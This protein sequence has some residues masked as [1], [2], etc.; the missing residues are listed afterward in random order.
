VT[1]GLTAAS[2]GL[3]L[4]AAFP[5]LDWSIC[6]WFGL[7]PL[8]RAIE[9]ESVGRALRLG[10]IAGVAF[11]LVALDWIPATIVRAG[12]L[13][14]FVAV[15]PLVALAGALAVYF[16]LFA[17]GL[18]YWQIHTGRD[19]FAF[20]VVL[21][22]AL[23]WCRATTLVAC[24]WE[25]IGYSQIMN[26]R[27][28]QIADVTGVYGVSA[29]VVAMNHALHATSARR[30]VAARFALVVAFFGAA[31]LYGGHRAKEFSSK[32]G[33]KALR[34]ALVQPAID[35][36]EK[37][38]PA[39]REAALAVQEELSRAAVAGGAELVVWPEASAPYLFAADDFYARD[40]DAFARDR[41]LRD[42]T[43]AFAR[44]LATPLLIGSPAPIVHRV[45]R[46]EVWNSLNRSLL[47][48]VDGTVVAHYDKTIL[49]PFGEYVPFA[50]LLF[51]VRRLVPG[52]G[53]FVAGTEPTAFHAG[54][55]RFAVLICYEA[56]FADFARRLV[57][58]GAEF[59]VNQTNDGWF[60]DS[61]APVEHLAMA[62]V[63]AI[64]NRVPLV[65]V[66]NTGISAVVRPD[67]RIDDVIAL[68]VRGVRVAEIR[69]GAPPRTF[70]TRHGDLFALTALLA[71]AIMLLYAGWVSPG[72]EPARVPVT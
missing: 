66:A 40:P 10:W 65:R 59:L 72:P 67:G 32:G 70:Y 21:W 36:N 16:A 57:D 4:A 37:W 25:L 39:R 58:D 46:G 27:L 22:V 35:A 42:R 6:A 2:S 34:V 43:T 48:G 30:A 55:A 24:P 68:G 69:P 62:S 15:F 18:R 44:E 5:A 51:F 47:L 49:V 52:V 7:V 50:R 45:G 8:L 3:L 20:A 53:D 63:R 64:E 56:T 54:G 26:R 33:D 11:F 12:G 14:P 1:A 28:M 71:A 9:G 17:A 19:G 31:I 29:L 41:M 60:G 23:E 13:G 61:S 38:D